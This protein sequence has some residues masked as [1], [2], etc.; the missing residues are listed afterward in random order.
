[1]LSP[2]DEQCASGNWQ[3]TCWQEE[4]AEM[5]ARDLSVGITEETKERLARRICRFARMCGRANVDV[6]QSV[7]SSRT[8]KR[9][10]YDHSQ[11]G[12]M[13]EFQGVAA[14][15]LLD[16]WMARAVR[17]SEGGSRWSRD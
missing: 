15:G 3:A 8:L 6:A 4:R 14:V 10:G 11:R 13:S 17:D 12:V 16:H 5:L 9:C 2:E 7:L 1:M